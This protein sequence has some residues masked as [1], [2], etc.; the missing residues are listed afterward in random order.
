MA[1][2]I[3]RAGGFMSD[4]ANMAKLAQKGPMYIIGSGRVVCT[5][6]DVG[7]LASLMAEDALQVSNAVTSIGGPRDM[8]WRQICETCF[9]IWDAP[10]R[11]LS[12]PVWLCHVA[13]AFIRPF[14]FQYY[15]LGKLMVFFSVNS[16]PTAQ[17]GR[18]DLG[19]Y[20][21]S[22]YRGER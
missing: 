12:V 9:S 17:R 6:V 16:V 3:I 13:L 4:F 22:H 20:L 8:T 18:I 11:I 1:W 5:P 21:R 19:T 15:A 2:V 10:V 7:E 14:S